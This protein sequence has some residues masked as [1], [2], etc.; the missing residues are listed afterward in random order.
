MAWLADYYAG[1]AGAEEL[2]PRTR[3]MLVE[4]GEPLRFEDSSMLSDRDIAR[5]REMG[6]SLQMRTPGG[7]LNT[8]AAD[9]N[10]LPGGRKLISGAE[11]LARWGSGARP[12]DD[13]FGV[14]PNLQRQAYTANQ[15]QALKVADYLA[16]FLP[17]DRISD[18][19]YKMTGV[20]IGAETTP[21]LLKR[22]S[23]EL[24]LEKTRAETESTR[25]Q[26][27]ERRLDTEQKRQ[28]A[29]AEKADDFGTLETGITNLNRLAD[30]AATI[31][32]DPNLRRVVGPVAGR[33]VPTTMPSGANIEANLFSLKAQVGFAALTALR[34]ASKTGGGLGNVSDN[35]IKNL[36]NSIAALELT[37][38]PENLRKSLDT[39]I[40]YTNNVREQMERGYRGKYGKLETELPRPA[41]EQ[42]PVAARSRLQPGKATEFGNGQVW[43]LH[44]GVPKRL[45]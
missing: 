17:P 31:R 16:Q 29:V 26:A 5:Y 10:I 44:N 18:E 32:D 15:T 45:K 20:R 22:K 34:A 13:P 27:A 14:V 1:R 11:A 24:G 8:V 37:Q 43:T 41:H 4:R 42:L 21:N 33:W 23:E 25:A 19:V 38:S 2:D 12:V 6:G 28:K 39:V 9:P 30:A 35:D 3:D 40:E 36:Q 7:G